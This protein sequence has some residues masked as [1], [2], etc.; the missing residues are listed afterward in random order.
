LPSPESPAVRPR[1]AF[2][3]AARLHLPL[4]R[5]QADMAV[6]RADVPVENETRRGIQT[7]TNSVLAGIH[8][9]KTSAVGAI[10]QRI[11]SQEWD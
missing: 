7:P 3:R 10:D 4:F 9:G 2:S 8:T 6:R 11:H 5:S 1:G